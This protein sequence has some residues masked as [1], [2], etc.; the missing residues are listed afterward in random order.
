MKRLL[1]VALACA[2]LLA[3][4]ASGS[5]PELGRPASAPV[6]SITT[7][8]LGTVTARRTR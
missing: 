3:G 1:P 7:R 8:G 5:T 2:L 4:C 6:T